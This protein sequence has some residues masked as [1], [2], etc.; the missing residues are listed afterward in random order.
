MKSS[1]IGGDKFSKTLSLP[2]Q[3]WANLET[4]RS[5]TRWPDLAIALQ[6][7]IDSK[8]EALI[9]VKKMEQTQLKDSQNLESK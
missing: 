1:K 6:D 3:T 9:L 7:C 8:Y 5:I 2:V 4:I